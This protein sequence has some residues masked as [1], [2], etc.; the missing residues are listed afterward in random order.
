MKKFFQVLGLGILI[1]A[2]LGI[3][4]TF[5]HPGWSGTTSPMDDSTAL[6]YLFFTT[7]VVLWIPLSVRLI[8]KKDLSYLFLQRE[9]AGSSILFGFIAGCLLFLAFLFAGL[10]FGVVSYKGY[11]PE[12]LRGVLVVFAIAF[13][14]QASSEEIMMRGLLTRLALNRFGRVAAILL[15]SIL[16]ALFHLGNHGVNLISIVNTAL[17]GIVFA[18]T[19]FLTKNLLFP[20]AMHAAWNFIQGP[21]LGFQ[22]SG[23]ALS[24][25]LFSFEVRDALLAGGSYGPENGLIVTVLLLILN[26]VLAFFLKKRPA[27]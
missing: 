13:F 8:F 21:I 6:T 14:I 7:G 3:L 17:V 20:C 18:E 19:L 2:I 4:L 12:H 27:L 25:H 10:A 16:F 24:T 5:Y 15:P 22:V 23:N 11:H 1:H 9:G 26:L